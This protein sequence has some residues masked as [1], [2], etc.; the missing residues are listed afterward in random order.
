MKH[1][2]LK[3][4]TGFSRSNHSKTYPAGTRCVRY[5][6][7]KHN[8]LLDLKVL[9]EEMKKAHKLNEGVTGPPR[10]LVVIVGGEFVTVLPRDQ[11]DLA[12]TDVP[13]PPI[14]PRGFT[15]P[16]DRP[17]DVAAAAPPEAPSRRKKPTP[18]RSLF[19]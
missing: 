19:E 8:E 13:D 10:Y 14:N 9:G 18:Q 12:E 1:L 7:I 17:V 16:V 4:S 2:T 11:M 3:A 6:A 15:T 5:E